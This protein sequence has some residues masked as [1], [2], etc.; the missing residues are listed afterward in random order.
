MVTK[1][2]TDVAKKTTLSKKEYEGLMKGALQAILK[3][4]R[5]YIFIKDKDIICRA[6]SDSFLRLMD[7][8]PEKLYGYPDSA[9][10]SK[11]L[12]RS[13]SGR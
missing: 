4:S 7:S 13:L 1:L 10:F 6:A 5:D 3:N 11:E 12:A 9:L 8:T 2:N